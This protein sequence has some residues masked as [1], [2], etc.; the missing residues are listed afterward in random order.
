M[1]RRACIRVGDAAAARHIG[2][3]HLD[4]RGGV[5]AAEIQRGNGGIIRIHIAGRGGH[6]DHAAQAAAVEALV[7]VLEGQ[8]AA[9]RALDSSNRLTGQRA[10][11]EPAISDARIAGLEELPLIREGSACAVHLHLD[12][13]RCAG[14]LQG[15]AFQRAAK[16]RERD[17]TA[18]RLGAHGDGGA[19]HGLHGRPVCLIAHAPHHIG[20]GL[21]GPEAG[22]RK[23]GLVALHRADEYILGGSITHAV[24]A[25]LLGGADAAGPAQGDAVG[26]EALRRQSHGGGGRGLHVLH[27]IANYGHSAAVESAVPRGKL[28]LEVV[29]GPLILAG[30][31]TGLGDRFAAD[32]SCLIG[33]GEAVGGAGRDAA[34][35]EKDVLRDRQIIREGIFRLVADGLA[36]HLG[37]TAV[38]LCPATVGIA[39]AGQARPVILHCILQTI[40]AAAIAGGIAGGTQLD[41]GLINRFKPVV[42]LRSLVVVFHGHHAGGG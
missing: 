10:Y 1:I 17:V 39:A 28:P 11:V 38:I 4:R 14:A 23:A 35:L 30:H 7:D 40:C 3:G 6:G 12:V 9:C 2:S 8:G 33:I 29:V 22:E 37:A 36:L 27:Q 21:A 15:A 5:Q 41:D 31:Y 13:R 26:G 20:V 16:Q 25:V 34:D 19:V 18:L 32:V 24:N 42:P